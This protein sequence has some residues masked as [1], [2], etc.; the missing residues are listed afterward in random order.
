M[1]V[2]FCVTKSVFEGGK[3]HLFICVCC[4]IV[5]CMC[6]SKKL[7]II[8]CWNNVELSLIQ[9]KFYSIKWHK[10]LTHRCYQSMEMFSPCNI[11]CMW[12][13]KVNDQTSFSSMVNIGNRKLVIDFLLSL[14]LLSTAWV[15]W[16]FSMFLE[17]KCILIIVWQITF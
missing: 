4:Y 7:K 2:G 5:T 1:E 10:T 17:W 13:T 12:R 6:I 15:T 3:S 9:I 8:C 16:V 14:S 11:L